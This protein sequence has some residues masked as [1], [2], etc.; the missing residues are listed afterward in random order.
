MTLESPS[1]ISEMEWLQSITGYSTSG[2]F[3]VDGAAKGTYGI[4]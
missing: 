4:G 1:A 2:S 3:T